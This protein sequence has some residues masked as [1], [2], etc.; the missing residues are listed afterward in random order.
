MSKIAKN[1]LFSA[2]KLFFF[3]KSC[4]IHQPG[5]EFYGDSESGE[6]NYL[7]RSKVKLFLIFQNFYHKKKQFEKTKKFI[8]PASIVCAYNFLHGSIEE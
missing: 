7:R 5:S 3:Q 6:K 4:I 8:T 1:G 2:K